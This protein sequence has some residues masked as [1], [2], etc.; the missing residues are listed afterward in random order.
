MAA[1]PPPSLQDATLEVLALAAGGRL[2][3]S[4]APAAL[5]ALLPGEELMAPTGPVQAAAADAAW[6]LWLDLGEVGAV[7]EGEEGGSEAW[8]RRLLEAVQA[9]L[10]AGLLSKPKL[11]ESGEPDF[12]AAVGVIAC[13]EAFRK[14]MLKINTRTFYVQEKYNLLCEES[15]GFAKLIVALYQ[16]AAHSE[17]E[18]DAGD[19]GD[20]GGRGGGG[21]A[22]ALGTLKRHVESLIGQFLLD[23]NRV[24]DLILEVLEDFPRCSPLVQLAEGFKSQSAR[25]FIG[26]KAGHY[27]AASRNAAAAEVGPGPEAASKA[28]DGG[29]RQ[30]SLDAVAGGEDATKSASPKER[31]VVHRVPMALYDAAGALVKAGL[32]SRAEIQELLQPD[33]GTVLEIAAE[34][35]EE[36]GRRVRKIGAVSLAG[37]GGGRAHGA[38]AKNLEMPNLRQKGGLSAAGLEME[39]GAYNTVFSR[40]GAEQDQQV[41]NQHFGLCCGAL[42]VQDWPTALAL[43]QDFRDEY[44]VAPAADPGVAH[45]L[46]AA[47]SELLEPVYIEYFPESEDNKA[48]TATR[49]ENFVSKISAAALQLLDHLGLHLYRDLRLMAK[50]S[51]ILRHEILIASKSGAARGTAHEVAEGLLRRSLLPALSLVPAN[52]ALAHEVWSVL[53]LLPYSDRFRVY[54][55]VIDDSESEPVLQAAEKLASVGVRKIMRRVTKPSNDKKE[56]EVM[57]QM[58]RMLAKLGHGSPLAAMRTIVQQVEAYEAMT[59]PVVDAL[60]FFSPLGFDVLTFTII[61]RFVTGGREKI[62]EDGVSIA[63]WF[64][65]LA[66]FTGQLCKKYSGLDLT[67]L[68]QYVANQLKDGETVDL[69]VLKELISK[70]A[71]IDTLEDLSDSQ[72]ESLAGGETLRLEALLSQLHRASPKPVQK[73][74]RRLRAALF[75][76]GGRNQQLAVPLLILIAQQKL[77][78]VFTA[79]TRHLKLLGEIVDRCN[80]VFI[81]YSAL[82][83]TALQPSSHYDQVLPTME[84]LHTNFGL[85]PEA[86]FH[87]YRPLISAEDVAGRGAGVAAGAEKD[88][89]GSGSVD[90]KFS[91]EDLCEA[92][93]PVVPASVPPAMHEFYFTFWSLSLYDVYFPEKRYVHEVD[94]LRAQASKLLKASDSHKISPEESSQLLRERDKHKGVMEAIEQEKEAHVQHVRAVRKALERSKNAWFAGGFNLGQFLQHCLFPRV[95]FSPGEALYCAKFIEVVH[96]LSTPG[97][98]MFSYLLEMTAIL[99]QMVFS[100]TQNE[101]ARLGIFLKETLRLLNTW[102][103]NDETFQALRTA[104]VFRSGDDGEPAATEGAQRQITREELMKIVVSLNEQLVVSLTSSLQSAEYMEVRNALQVLTKI[105]KHFPSNLE[106][107][108]RSLDLAGR[109]RDCAAKVRDEDVREDLKTLARCYLGMLQG[110]VQEL[111]RLLPATPAPDAEE[112][113]NNAAMSSGE[114]GELMPE[115]AVREGGTTE[116]VAAGHGEVQTVIAKKKGNAGEASVEKKPRKRSPKDKRRKEGDDNCRICGEPGHWARSCPRE[117]LKGSTQKGGTP[118]GGPGR[119]SRGSGQKIGMDR[120]R[121]G[122]TP[123]VTVGCTEVTVGPL[124]MTVAAKMV[125]PAAAARLQRSASVRRTVTQAR[126]GTG[127]RRRRGAT[128]ERA[129]PGDR[130]SRSPTVG[131]GLSGGPPRGTGA[132]PSTNTKGG[133][134]R[135]DLAKGL[136]LMETTGAVAVVTSGAGLGNNWRCRIRIIS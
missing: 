12:L 82:L 126:G 78:S 13:P 28:G 75:G 34:G 33:L 25:Y 128:A 121:G 20:G 69:L 89:S 22:V 118:A 102:A 43:L 90:R 120:P 96:G 17:R 116:A 74:V 129:A 36:Q 52:P 15:E 125:V 63:D 46:C 91:W 135:S 39:G 32:A 62:K 16:F 54:N 92:A 21:C 131:V 7:A 51:R 53:E 38:T 80:E 45:A 40:E 112:P 79:E 24:L 58:G 104:E 108:E 47:I 5:Q 61:M 55:Q 111:R 4:R 30:E 105:V 133:A 115:D 2:L 8:R 10:A 95:I 44:H 122:G 94:S 132:G 130:S 101:A 67:A 86:V 114:D 27:H 31:H 110:K 127:C 19:R 123:G 87:L 37:L 57:K 49:G 29:T 109:V 26:F 1:G 66:S 71:L 103:S 18:S 56:K 42:N 35:L 83:W 134:R 64:Q 93:R 65:N 119:N 48:E 3:P 73:C 106:P 14:Q 6:L 113:G 76:Q 124:G 81:Q 50:L 72:I 41:S 85:P 68:C 98:D 97:F 11:L 88:G 59:G 77:A 84:K 9:L 117:A 107:T 136:R 99:S 23:P 70:M 100:C 60:R